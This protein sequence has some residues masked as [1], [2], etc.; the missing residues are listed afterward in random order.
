MR[1]TIA[2][3]ACL[4]LGGCRMVSPPQGPV[5]PGLAEFLPPATVA[6][7]G[8]QM[9]RLRQAP[10][11]QKL[12]QQGS[13]PMLDGFRTDTGIDPDRDVRQLLLA[14]DGRRTLAMARGTFQ[15]K[16]P[17]G[18]RASAYR[19]YT[20]WSKDSGVTIA[21]PD[22]T[23]VLGG[24]GALV[25]AA[26]DNR[27]KGAPPD[28]MARVA[29]ISPDVESWAVV[30]AWSKV[31]P[32]TL[33]GNAA[34]L[35]RVLRSVEG[36]TLTVSFRTGVTAAATGDCR[37]PQE[38]LELSENLRGLAGLLRLGVPRDRPEVARRFDGM[39]ITQEDRR[40]KWSL[41]IPPDLADSLAAK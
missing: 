27:K 33:T 9:D 36:A 16:P 35:D 20:L 4:A 5:D 21:F 7:V 14:S 38:A 23:T 39:R 30:A 13:L 15:T 29:T 34:N 18:W 26:I 6:L 8:V 11:Y 19:G 28:V 37:T 12:A 41:E 40:V 17:D 24:P 31:P 22:R 25:R 2:A 3:I 1:T 10:L 32:G